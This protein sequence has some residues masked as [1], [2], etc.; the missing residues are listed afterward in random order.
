MKTKY[1]ILVIPL[2][3]ISLL[4]YGFYAKEDSIADDLSQYD[5]ATFSAG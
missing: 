4:A 3:I 1:L 5:Y 2:V